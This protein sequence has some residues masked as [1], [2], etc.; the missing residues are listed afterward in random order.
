MDAHFFFEV[1]A[2]VPGR[3]N[4]C[5]V[6]LNIIVNYRRSKEYIRVG[7]KLG[8]G[9]LLPRIVDETQRVLLQSFLAH[10]SPLFSHL[11]PDSLVA[12]QQPNSLG[13]F[14]AV[15]VFGR[16]RE[17]QQVN[18][19]CRGM[20]DRFFQSHKVKGIIRICKVHVSTFHERNRNISSPSRPRSG[21]R[22][23][24]IKIGS[25]L[26][27]KFQQTLCRGSVRGAVVHDKDFKREVVGTLQS[28][29][30][31]LQHA[32]D[33]F[34]NI[35]RRNN[36]GEI[37]FTRIIANGPVVTN[38]VQAAHEFRLHSSRHLVFGDPSGGLDLG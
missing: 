14:V 3:C 27:G 15:D 38:L 26:R 30:H 2:N 25:V 20:P 21:G 10:G 17:K 31:V 24:Q 6:K 8:A 1:K 33:E 22:G 12:R 37:H 19:R 36:D 7:E 9:E 16:V 18:V 29:E 34:S 5:P 11:L 35:V 23:E 13:G 28:R 4:R 32:R